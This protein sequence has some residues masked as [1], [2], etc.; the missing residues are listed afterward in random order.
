MTESVDNH[1]GP[2]PPPGRT[3]AP[4]GLAVGADPRRPVTPANRGGPR[5]DP[6]RRSTAPDA[7][8]ASGPTALLIGGSEDL[9]A[10]LAALPRVRIPVQR[11]AT[12]PR[13]ADWLAAPLILITP[14]AV[15]RSAGLPRRPGVILLVDADRA[16]VNYATDAGRLRAR[17]AELGDARVLVWPHCAGLLAELLHATPRRARRRATP[18][19]AATTRHHHP[20]THNPREH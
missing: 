7:S 18:R 5:L 8:S 13:P 20:S 14:D 15:G 1:S 11:P 4:G 10:D 16:P 2:H 17:A 9:R 6:P 3:P 12:T 19:P